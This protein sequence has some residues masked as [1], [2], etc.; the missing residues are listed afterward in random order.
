MTQRQSVGEL[1]WARW[2]PR[3]LS[4]PVLALC[5]S[6]QWL[7]SFQTP[8]IP[9]PTARHSFLYQSYIRHRQCWAHCLSSRNGMYFI[10]SGCWWQ[11]MWS[12]EE[13]W[14]H[15]TAKPLNQQGGGRRGCMP[16]LICGCYLFHSHSTPTMCQAPTKQPVGTSFLL[17]VTLLSQMSQ[18][19]KSPRLPLQWIILRYW[20]LGKWSRR[21]RGP[22]K[23]M[24]TCVH[25]YNRCR[26]P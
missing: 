18:D 1:C 13:P 3:G 19:A 21:P 23:G 10:D 14:T 9:S 2:G 5:L 15:Q 17:V 25:A 4:Q 7:H 26:G 20:K 11:D 24:A 6:E 22:N 16:A 12:T 8:K